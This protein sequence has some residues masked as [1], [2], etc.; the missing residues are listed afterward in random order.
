MIDA[1]AAAEIAQLRAELA[2][3]GQGNCL[4][5]KSPGVNNWVTVPARDAAVAA[6]RE[7]CAKVCDDEAR[8]WEADGKGPATEARLCAARIRART[9][10]A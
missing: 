10:P 9:N 6:E 4:G 5:R 1:K 7:G 3:C 2:L 8:L